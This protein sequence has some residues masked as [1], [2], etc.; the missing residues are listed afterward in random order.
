MFL[1][2]EKYNFWNKNVFR[3]DLK[4][5]TDQVCIFK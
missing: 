2:T 3:A 5:E 1:K 4:D